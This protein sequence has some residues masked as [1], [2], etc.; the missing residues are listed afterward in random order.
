MSLERASSLIQDNVL[1][2]DAATFALSALLI[3]AP[4]P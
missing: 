3:G 2:L 4:L 1:W